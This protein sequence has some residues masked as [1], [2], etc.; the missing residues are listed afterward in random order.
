MMKNKAMLNM[1]QLT[2]GTKP[3]IT[4]HDMFLVGVAF[5]VYSVSEALERNDNEEV[6]RRLIKMEQEV[7]SMNGHDEFWKGVMSR[8]GY[9]H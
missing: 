8:Y 7:R 5:A 4:P 9:E 1:F 6:M 2:M 3:D